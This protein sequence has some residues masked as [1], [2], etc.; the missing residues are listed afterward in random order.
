MAR[1]NLNLKDEDVRQCGICLLGIHLP[2]QNYCMLV[3]YKEGK[4]F[5]K[6]YYHTQC[7]N[8]RVSGGSKEMKETARSLLNRA[9]LLMDKADGGQE[10]Y[11]LTH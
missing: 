11:E 9:K 1:T 4:E 10:V 3:D 8:E 2:T 5:M 7:Y 6:G